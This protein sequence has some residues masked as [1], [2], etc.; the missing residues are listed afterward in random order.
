MR[1]YLVYQTLNILVSVVRKLQLLNLKHAFKFAT[2]KSCMNLEDITLHTSNHKIMTVGHSLY[3]NWRVL[4]HCPWFFGNDHH[5]PNMTNFTLLSFA[6]E[7]CHCNYNNLCQTQTPPLTYTTSLPHKSHCITFFYG[8]M[9]V[10][11]MEQQSC[12]LEAIF[13]SSTRIIVLHWSVKLAQ[14]PCPENRSG[15]WGLWSIESHQ[16]F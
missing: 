13:R 6:A 7:W 16:G 14:S 9:I 10:E 12:Q 4:I 1:S 11:K 3:P 5:F 15:G 2:W 8:S